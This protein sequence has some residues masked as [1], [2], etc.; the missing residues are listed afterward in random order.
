MILSPVWEG[1][2]QLSWTVVEDIATGL[3]SVG[4]LGTIR[5]KKNTNLKIIGKARLS[6]HK[7]FDIIKNKNSNW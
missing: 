3:S 1:L 7:V 6:S 4:W 2:F 5:E